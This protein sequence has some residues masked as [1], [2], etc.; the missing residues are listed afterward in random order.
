MIF[1]FLVSYT[2]NVQSSDLINGSKFIYRA[3]DGNISF[4][5]NYYFGSYDIATGINLRTQED[6]EHPARPI[7]YS[8]GHGYAKIIQYPNGDLIFGA[9]NGGQV[10]AMRA[11]VGGYQTGSNDE[12]AF[13][14]YWGHDYTYNSKGELF[15]VRRTYG[16]SY[17]AGVN[18]VPYPVIGDDLIEGP[19]TCNEYDAGTL[20]D[21]NGNIVC[22][23]DDTL[24]VIDR[25]LVRVIIRDPNTEVWNA[26]NFPDVI[27]GGS[28][29]SPFIAIE[30]II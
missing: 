19:A 22:S 3:S 10:N 24:A 7:N 23:T 4:R 1:I 15:A 25:N 13:G 28:I 17:R 14:S 11:T 5:G 20:Y 26:I 2:V 16:G 29:V 30:E 12:E 9:L 18:K 27:P 6:Y 21:F 8:G